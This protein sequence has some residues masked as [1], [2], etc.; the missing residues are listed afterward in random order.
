MKLIETT[1]PNMTQ[2]TA[3]LVS[4]GFTETSISTGS[5]KDKV[6]TYGDCPIGLVLTKYNYTTNVGSYSLWYPQ[7][8]VKGQTIDIGAESNQKVKI[9]YEHIKEGGIIICLRNINSSPSYFVALSAPINEGAEWV[10]A[11]QHGGDLRL[12]ERKIN[13]NN[14]VY[15]EVTPYYGQLINGYDYINNKIINNILLFTTNPYSSSYTY[16]IFTINGKKYLGFDVGSS[17]GATRLKIAFEITD[18]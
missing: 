5:D 7:S 6:L 17:S 1:T 14:L 12:N 11:V 18:D 10:T 16:I 9:Y 3:A 8:G 2:V 13:A 15:T 4:L